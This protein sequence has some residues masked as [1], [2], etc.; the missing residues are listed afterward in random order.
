MREREIESESFLLRY[1]QLVCKGGYLS[2]VLNCALSL[3]VLTCPPCPWLEFCSPLCPPPCAQAVS[4]WEWGVGLYQDCPPQ[5]HRAQ[6]LWEDLHW[7]QHPNSFYKFLSKFRRR[8]IL[9]V[10]PELFTWW[11]IEIN[12]KIDF[13]TKCLF[14]QRVP[15]SVCVPNLSAILVSISRESQHLSCGSFFS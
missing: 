14:L 4:Q 5:W 2:H 6:E 8:N 1:A 10:L 9:N 3:L 11:A 13:Q 12:K 7:S 15:W